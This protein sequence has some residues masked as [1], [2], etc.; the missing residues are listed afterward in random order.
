MKSNQGKISNDFMKEV[1]AKFNVHPLI[2]ARAKEAPDGEPANT[3]HRKGNCGRKAIYTLHEIEQR[4]KGAPLEHR[5]TFR[6]LALYTKLSTWA[7]WKYMKHRWIHRRSNWTRCSR[8]VTKRY[9]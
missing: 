8:L 1:C 3:K 4:I 2:M 7:I 9:E 5:Q 6:G